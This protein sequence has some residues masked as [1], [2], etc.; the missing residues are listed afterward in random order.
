MTT[1]SMHLRM[2]VA[3]LHANPQTSSPLNQ[4][5]VELIRLFQSWTDLLGDAHAML[6]LTRKSDG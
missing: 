1:V 3:G 6:Y 5:N 4:R 2:Y